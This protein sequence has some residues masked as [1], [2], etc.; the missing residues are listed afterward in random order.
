MGGGG[1]VALATG[2][3]APSG[4]RLCALRAGRGCPARGAADLRVRSPARASPAPHLLGGRAAPLARYGPP[5][6]G[7]LELFNPDHVEVED[8]KARYRAGTVGDVEVKQKL[9]RALNAFLEPLRERRTHYEAHLDDVRD[10]LRD[11]TRRANEVANRHVD[12]IM[13]R[14]GLF[15]P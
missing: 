4:R 7:H 5:A 9:A 15:R 3:T 10:I 2:A 1:A 13:Q 8:L 11:G 12:K 14:M 6:P